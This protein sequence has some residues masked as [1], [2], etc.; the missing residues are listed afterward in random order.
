MDAITRLEAIERLLGL[1]AFSAQKHKRPVITESESLTPNYISFNPT[2]GLVTATFAGVFTGSLTLPEGTAAP[3]VQNVVEWLDS[4]NVLQ[5]WISGFQLSA[6]RHQLKFG[7]GSLLT[8]FTYVMDGGGPGGPRHIFSTGGG[9]VTVLDNNGASSF[10]Q[11]PTPLRTQELFGSVIA[12][13]PAITGT[14]SGGWGIA[15]SGAGVYT[16]SF[17]Q[18]FADAGYSAQVTLHGAGFAVINNA[19]K[20]AGSFVLDIFNTGIVATDINFDLDVV[21]VY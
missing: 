10:V 16:I 15:R 2:T 19:S 12:A 18:A 7:V 8:G 14:S 4:T 1:G 3:L 9:L 20:L 13:T 21:G 5:E 6:G 11:L 17:I